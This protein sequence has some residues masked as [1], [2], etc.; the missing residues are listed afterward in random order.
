[1]NRSD[2]AL[3]NSPAESEGRLDRAI[4]DELDP[5]QQSEASY[6]TDL[7]TCGASPALEQR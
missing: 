6:I 2:H 1:L 3:G 4:C 7:S 5:N